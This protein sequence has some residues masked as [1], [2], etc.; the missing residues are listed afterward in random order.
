MLYQAP[1][2][3]PLVDSELPRTVFAP[4]AWQG[5]S[6]KY[7]FVNTG[8]IVHALAERNIRPYLA[9][10]SHA[11]T[12]SRIGYTKHMLRFR[13]DGAVALPGGVYP[14]IVITNSHDTGSAFIAELGLYRLI[15]KNGLVASYGD[16]ARYRGIHKVLSIESV[17]DGVC[18]IVHQFPML[19]DTVQRMQTLQLEQAK[20]EAFAEAASLLR[21]DADKAPFAPAVLLRTRRTEDEAP[22]VWNTFNVIQ[23]NLLQGQ[24]M[25]FSRFGRSTRAVRSIDVDLQLNK[26]L[27]ELASHYANA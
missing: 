10:V 15:C 1:A 18:S 20:R 24:S 4:H 3:R 21:W 26:G 25:R 22:T 17:L 9:K 19:A 14:E 16:F 7:A 23:E 8:D 6:D 2:V 12:D 27:W 13:E 5:V 11:R